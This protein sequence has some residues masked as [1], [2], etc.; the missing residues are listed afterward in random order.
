MLAAPQRHEF[1]NDQDVYEDL[2]D[3]P[4]KIYL[5]LEVEFFYSR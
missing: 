1:Q 4:S 5:C 3:E 2:A